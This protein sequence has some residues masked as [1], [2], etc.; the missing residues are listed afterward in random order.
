M[1]QFN[2]QLVIGQK[3]MI[4]G[5][6]QPQN[7]FLIGT[8]VTLEDIWEADQDVTS[9]Y[10]GAEQGSSRVIVNADRT[11]V[12]SGC[13]VTGGTLS[14]EYQMEKG[15]TNFNLNYLMPIPPLEEEEL[16]REKELSL[17]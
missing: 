16:Q 3:C 7:A 15:W 6:R 12:V 17:V 13:R 2:N 1:Q 8:V 11:A 10:L 4:I 14:G 9:F 5:V